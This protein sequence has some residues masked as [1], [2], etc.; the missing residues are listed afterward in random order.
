MAE[1]LPSGG[2]CTATSAGPVL[3]IVSS[4]WPQGL[5]LTEEEKAISVLTL[6]ATAE[7]IICAGLASAGEVAAALADL[8]GFAATPGTVIGG[9]RTFQV[10]ARRSRD[11]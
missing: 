1:T 11:P 4:G 2:N 9:P 3:P 5:A 6:E 10:W 7:A 8:R